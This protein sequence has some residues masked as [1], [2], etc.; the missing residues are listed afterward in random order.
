[1]ANL[2]RG[3]VLAAGCLVAALVLASGAVMLNQS[4]GGAVAGAK[5]GASGSFGQ[6]KIGGPFHLTDQ[7]GKAVDESVLKG[8]W[9]A[10]FFGYTYCPD[11]CPTNLQ[12]LAHA[13]DK[14]G[15]K[16]KDFQVVF[17]SIDPGRDKPEAL[18]AYLSNQGFPKGALGLTGTDAQ[19]AEAAKAYRV[20][21][22]RSGKGSDYLMDHSTVTYLMDPQGRFHG[23]IRS[24]ATPDEAAAEISK[25]MGG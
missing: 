20:Y 18:K 19:V 14:L 24:D 5:S 10:V 9:S 7:N 15:T 16:A 22:A 12:L 3:A 6:A 1:M 17:V 21:Y 8:K 4:Q 13:Q 11:F 25:A 2:P 23:L